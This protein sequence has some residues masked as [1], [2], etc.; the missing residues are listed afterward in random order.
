[1]STDPLDRLERLFQA[2]IMHSPEERTAF[3][4]AACADEPALRDELESLLRA[5]EAADQDDFLDED[6]S[7]LGIKDLYPAKADPLEGRQVGPYTIQRS[8]GRGGMGDVYLAVRHHPFKR[9][10][11]LKIIRRGIDTR[12]VLMRFEVERQILASLSHPNVARLYDGGMTSEGLPYFAMEYVQ[13]KQI[14]EYCD[15][16]HLSIDE[17]IKLFQIV[18]DAVQ[19]THQN[20][21]IHRD[22]KPSN[23]LVT[24]EGVVKLLDFGI[25]KLLNPHLSPLSLPATNTDLRPMTPEYAS[26]EQVRGESLTTASDTYSLGVL[27][28]ELLTGHRPYH[29]K[30]R[31]ESEIT[32]V[33]CEVDPERPSTRIT[34]AERTAKESGTTRE[35]TPEEVSRT[36]GIPINRLKRLLRGDLDN[37]VMMALH[38]DVRHRY[39]TAEQLRKDLDRYL[40][41]RPVQARSYSTGY[42]FR[43]F[44]QR[45]RVE[46]G[47]FLVVLA[48]LIIGLGA[49][50]WQWNIAQQERDRSNQALAQSEAVTAFVTD[51]F[52]ANS[53][54]VSRGEDLTARMLLDYGV[55]K[56]DEL[57]D[58]PAAQAELLMVIGRMHRVLGNYDEAED[59]FLQSLQKNKAVIGEEHVDVANLY[60]ELGMLHRNKANFTEADSFLSRAVNLYAALS[61]A[62]NPEL[63]R[64]KSHQARSFSLGGDHERAEPILRE[65]LGLQIQVHGAEHQDVAQTSTYLAR[66]LRSTAQYEE[67]EVMYRE[68]L[69]IYRAVYG[70]EHT[71]TATSMNNLGMLLREIGQYPEAEVMYREA[72]AVQRKLHGEANVDLAAMINNLAR[73][74]VLQSK[75]DEAEQLHREALAMRRELFGEEHASVASSF[76]NVASVM[77]RKGNYEEAETYSRQALAMRRELLGSDH[78]LTAV[79][80][81]NL[82]L[83]LYRTARCD[84]AIVL[85]DEALAIYDKRFS[86]LRSNTPVTVSNLATCYRELGRFDEAEQLYIEAL[87]ME[88]TLYG[89][90]DHPRIAT[91]LYNLGVLELERGNTARADSFLA[92]SLAMR[93][94]VLQ[95]DH[96][97]I[98]S[99][100]SSQGHVYTTMGL[101]IEAEIALLEGAGHL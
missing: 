78:P 29:L 3:L 52:E 44:V 62:K 48:S 59:L 94:K 76:D 75:Y 73:L 37:I 1:M 33:V 74:M 66:V 51:L 84:E 55:E 63:L 11:A 17:R 8:L 58:Q 82:G 15:A 60:L 53:P 2:A 16:N 69:R 9:Y 45:H 30:N 21:I 38:K 97:S 42:R 101:Y 100:R 77:S 4:D 89:D 40:D 50:L 70:N 41:G 88:Q 36:R 86:S 32:R 47:A 24:K 28:Y 99:T 43:K 49:A 46:T 12:D 81:N 35:I 68:A 26:P 93:K 96:L 85:Y 5:D 31:T 90:V 10:V 56:L 71:Q 72:L 19:H 95:E 83:L 98:A 20:L 91:R 34:H 39:G 61:G 25:A 67:A 13:G 27:L 80:L 23:I 22:L 79:S 7:P 65:V 57:N 54:N 87:K 18:C 92:K 6:E 64:A 14:T